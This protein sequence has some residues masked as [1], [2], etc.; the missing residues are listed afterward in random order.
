[1]VKPK[2][3]LK[4]LAIKIQIKGSQPSAAPTPTGYIHK[5]AAVR[6]SP[7]GAAAGCDLLIV[8][9]KGEARKLRLFCTYRLNP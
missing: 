7:V 2:G 6:K 1:M 4:P 8:N 9:K 5:I 3:Y